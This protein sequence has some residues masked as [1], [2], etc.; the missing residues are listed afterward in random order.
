MRRSLRQLYER[1][2]VPPELAMC[3]QFMTALLLSWAASAQVRNQKGVV[4]SVAQEILVYGPTGYITPTSL[5]ANLWDIGSI[6]RTEAD[7]ELALGALVEQ[8]AASKVLGDRYMLT[9]R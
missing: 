2:E 4:Q 3:Q 7:I 9:G 1:G 8:G 6:A 5:R